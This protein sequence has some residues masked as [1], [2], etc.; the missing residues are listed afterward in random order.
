MYD[1]LN[2]IL[3][4]GHV[5]FK[6]EFRI[7]ENGLIYN[8]NNRLSLNGS[9]VSYFI[10]LINGKYQRKEVSITLDN[11]QIIS[12]NINNFTAHTQHQ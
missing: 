5:R 8:L 12:T 7:N 9:F 10:G 4:S 3:I 2:N 6:R 1:S 11:G